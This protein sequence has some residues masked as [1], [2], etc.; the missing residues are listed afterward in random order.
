MGPTYSNIDRAAF[1]FACFLTLA[2]RFFAA[3][4]SRLFR[5]RQNTLLSALY[6]YSPE[7]PAFFIIGRYL[8]ACNDLHVPGVY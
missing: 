5:S 7:M 1:S 2:R 3:F 4:G 6:F 8:A